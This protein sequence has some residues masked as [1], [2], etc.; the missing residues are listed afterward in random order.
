MHASTGSEKAQVVERIKARYR[1]RVYYL[2]TLF[3]SVPVQVS[4]LVDYNEIIEMSFCYIVVAALFSLNY[5]VFLLL[6]RYIHCSLDRNVTLSRCSSK[7]K[8]DV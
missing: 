4:A 1:T 7:L 3:C 6:L 5:Y 8:Y 2:L